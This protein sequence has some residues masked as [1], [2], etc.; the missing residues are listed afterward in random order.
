MFKTFETL[1]LFEIFKSFVTL[2][3]R[4]IPIN[5]SS[6]RSDRIEWISLI[7]S[8][9]GLQLI[10]R[11]TTTRIDYVKFL[12]LWGWCCSGAVPIKTS[13]DMMTPRLTL[14]AWPGVRGGVEGTGGAE[15]KLGVGLETPFLASLCCC[16]RGNVALRNGR[17]SC[18]IWMRAKSFSTKSGWLI[19]RITVGFDSLALGPPS[20]VS[21]FSVETAW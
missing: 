18:F 2:K 10:L 3:S 16:S 8:F 19:V 4:E 21:K 9:F 5:L 7:D 14:R 20:T 15:R 11:T 1:K 6:N 17:V 12:C 13:G